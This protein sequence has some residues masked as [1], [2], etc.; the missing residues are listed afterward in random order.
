MKWMFLYSTIFSLPFCW[1]DI[2][3]IDYKTLPVKTWFE[4]IYVVVFATF[5]SY[6]LIPVGQKY[7]RPTIVSMYN[8][9]Q[10][11]VSSIVAVVIGMDIFGWKKALAALLVFL[12]V[13]IVTQSK[14]RAQ[15]EAERIKQS[16]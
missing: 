4:I 7:L 3:I 8:Y 14:S 12:G 10:P 11:V 13:Y 2:N 16:K 1:R 15:M 6:F 9:V 5:I